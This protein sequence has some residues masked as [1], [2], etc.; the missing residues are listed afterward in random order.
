M[1]MK[2]RRAQFFEKLEKEI[3]V[4]EQKAKSKG[5]NYVNESIHQDPELAEIIKK[6]AE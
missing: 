1:R 6:Q 3:E 5:I 4:D 2:E